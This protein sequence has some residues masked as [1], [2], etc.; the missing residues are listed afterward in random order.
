MN[1]VHQKRLS[2]FLENELPNKKHPRFQYA[3]FSLLNQKSFANPKRIPDD[4]LTDVINQHRLQ[5]G[6]SILLVFVN[7]YFMPLLSDLHK[8]P[9]EIIACSRSAALIEYKELIAQAEMLSAEKENYIFAALNADLVTD[10]LFF[11]IP[12]QC[13]IASPLHLLSIVFE[14]QD[15]IANPRHF[16][17]LGEQSKLTLAEE[18]FNFNDAAYLMN[19]VTTIQ[20]KKNATLNHYK[21]QRESNQAIHLAHTFVEQAQNSQY[22]FTNFSLGS[23]FA[24]DDMLIALKE[25]GT[26]CETAGFYSL[27]N[28]EQ[29]VDHHIDILHN[30]AHSKSAMLYKGIL[31]NKSRAVFNGKLYVDKQAQK[32]EALQANHNLLLS[33]DAHVYS[34]PELE[35]YADD[36]KCKHGATIGEIDTD[37]L[38]YLR[39]RGIPETEAVNLILQGFA[40]DIMQRISHP[41][42]KLRV[43]ELM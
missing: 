25:P 6:T 3:D 14:Q 43:E 34:K 18:H 40:D 15:F 1:D 11:Y 13:E 28:D 16:F 36:V 4:K 41:G 9:K 35:I 31:Y 29:Y 20:L 21:I 30:A 8:L 27:Y 2:A 26:I 19:I 12:D 5:Q 33:N 23:R 32:I 38:F 10:G 7:G 17:I 22:H 24:R 42:I 37:V 39:S